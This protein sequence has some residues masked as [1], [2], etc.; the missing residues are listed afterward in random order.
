[1]ITW[2]D[3]FKFTVAYRTKCASFKFLNLDSPALNAPENFSSFLF[4]KENPHFSM[5]AVHSRT[6]PSSGGTNSKHSPEGHL[7]GCVV[8][9]HPHLAHSSRLTFGATG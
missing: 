4:A 1:M 2:P 3:G 9:K 6:L 5:A 7:T 8:L